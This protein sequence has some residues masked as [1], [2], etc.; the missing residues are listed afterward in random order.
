MPCRNFKGS[1]MALICTEQESQDQVTAD[2]TR[3]WGHF[4]FRKFLVVTTVCYR[5]EEHLF[6]RTGG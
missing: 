6:R 4:L 1:S 2:A 5:N 3:G